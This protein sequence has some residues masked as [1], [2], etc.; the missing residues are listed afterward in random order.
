MLCLFDRAQRNLELLQLLMLLLL[1]T[2]MM[3]P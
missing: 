2:T 3:M 1:L